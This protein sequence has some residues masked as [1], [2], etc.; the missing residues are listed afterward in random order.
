MT[1]IYRISAVLLMALLTACSGTPT[2][3]GQT[4][5]QPREIPLDPQLSPREQVNLWLERAANTD[6][7][8]DKQR[9]QLKAAELLLRE[10]QLPLAEEL[11]GNGGWLCTTSSR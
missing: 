2:A 7:I 11:L 6:E 9:Y 8:P 4:G 5:T 1:S 3:P 10:L